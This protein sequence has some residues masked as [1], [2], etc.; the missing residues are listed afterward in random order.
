MSLNFSYKGIP[1]AICTDPN[2]PEQYHPVL[3]GIVWLALACGF[4]RI[5]YENWEK[6]AQRIMELQMVCG[7]WLCTK[8]TAGV[9]KP[10]YILPEDVKQYIGFTA[11]VTDMT[12]AQWRKYI[13]TRLQERAGALP[14]TC[15]I[16]AI[17][18]INSDK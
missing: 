9:Q 12:D 1:D 8:G 3:D 18:M 17:A 15:A 13:Y 14:S 10:L 11:N 2:D 7:A 6:V 4:S 5:T 16:S